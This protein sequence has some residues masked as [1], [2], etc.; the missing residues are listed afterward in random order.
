MNEKICLALDVSSRK[1]AMDLVRPLRDLTGMFKVG[2]QLFT[3]EG[4]FADSRDHRCR[5]KGF[6]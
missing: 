5:R 2:M 6:P 1:E 3:A 4:T